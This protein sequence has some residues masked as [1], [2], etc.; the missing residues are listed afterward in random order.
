MGDRIETI[1][2]AVLT[3]LTGGKLK[4][5][6]CAVD[7]GGLATQSVYDY[8]TKR[9]GQG[10]IAIKGSSR[11]GVPII[12]KGTK[13]DINYSGRVRKKSG[14]VYIIN[15]E[16]I[17]DKIFSKIKSKEKIHFHAETTEEYFKE[18]TGEY[19]TLKTNKKGYPVSTYEKKPNQAVEKLDCCV[20]AFSM[21][22]LLLKT[23]PKGLFFTNY[24]KKLLNNTNLNTKN[25]LRSRQKAK[26]SSYVTNW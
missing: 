6:G 25:T 4:I 12:G 19:R 18:L 23:V 17:K 22:Y 2:W 8:C 21:Y 16:D 20:Y 15:T 14:I 26:K 1:S 3:V 5:S 10:V 24:A 13:V 7:S 9:R 11:S